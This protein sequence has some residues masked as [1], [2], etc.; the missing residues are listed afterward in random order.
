M[1]NNAPSPPNERKRHYSDW[2]LGSIEPRLFAERLC[3]MENDT[4]GLHIGY[5]SYEPSLERLEHA[6]VEF[7]NAKCM[8]D[9]HHSK[10]NY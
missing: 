10:H 9:S 7:D 2:N 1:D 5:T 4:K 8:Y 3:R 6:H